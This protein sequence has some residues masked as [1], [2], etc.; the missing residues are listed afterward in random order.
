LKDIWAKQ[1]EK[2]AEN[3]KN[4][5]LYQKLGRAILTRNLPRL[6]QLLEH[7]ADVNYAPKNQPHPMILGAKEGDPQ[8]FETLLGAGG[9]PNAV[10]VKGKFLDIGE[11]KKSLIHIAIE[12][13]N[14]SIALMLARDPRMEYEDS[15]TYPSY[16]LGSLADLPHDTPL[17]LAVDAGM[18]KLAA[19]LARRRAKD[20]R[21][22][23]DKLDDLAFDGFPKGEKPPKP[24]PKSY[25]IGPKPMLKPKR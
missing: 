24:F 11:D 12:S 19:V 22:A 2:R 25:R 7:G 6:K 8:I 23:A 5:E 4:N 3:K 10:L 17:D 13:G 14:E 16:A 1:T 21:A 20:L 15:G 18:E 9:D